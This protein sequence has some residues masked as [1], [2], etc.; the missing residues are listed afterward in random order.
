MRRGFLVLLLVLLFAGSAAADIK[1]TGPKLTPGAA[2]DVLRRSPALAH[3]KNQPAPEQPRAESVGIG[4]P[5][6]LSWLAFPPERPRI[7]LDGTP[8]TQPLDVYGGVRFDFGRSHY[9]RR[10]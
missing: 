10:R 6:A 4:T 5:G 1:W 8:L 9:G 2:A 3:I 7:R